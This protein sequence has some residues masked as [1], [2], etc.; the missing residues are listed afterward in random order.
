M[1]YSPTYVEER[2]TLSLNGLEKNTTLP[3]LTTISQQR[4][5]SLDFA[6]ISLLSHVLNWSI[7]F[8]LSNSPLMPNWPPGLLL[9][10]LNKDRIGHVKI[11]LELE[12][13]SNLSEFPY[14]FHRY[15]TVFPL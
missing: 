7:V 11:G 9:G 15:W 6:M 3:Y 8:V 1:H 5:F 14:D 13:F 10:S 2:V 12:V 4:T